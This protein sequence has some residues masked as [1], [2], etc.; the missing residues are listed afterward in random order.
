MNY[1]IDIM[2]SKNFE[3]IRS[4][5]QELADLAG[6]AEYYTFTDPASS[7][8]KLRSFIE[9]VVFDIYDF[10][11]LAKPF[12]ASLNDLLHESAFINVT[13][14]VVLLKIDAIRKYGNQAAHGETKKITPGVASWLVKESFD[15]AKYYFLALANGAQ[16]DIPVYKALIPS[17]NKETKLSREQKQLKEELKKKEELLNSTLKELERAR[18]KAVELNKTDA[19]LKEIKESSHRVSNELGF[20]EAET[21]KYI[22]DQELMAAGWDVNDP[23]QVGIEVPVLHQPT[24]TGDGYVDYVLWNDDGT[25]LAVVEAKRTSVNAKKGKTQA[26]HYA[27]GLEKMTGH[28]PIIFFTNG[29]D[30]YFWDDAK[31]EGERPVFGYYS[32]DSLQRVYQRTKLQKNLNELLPN[33]NIAGRMY[34][35]EAIKRVFERYQDNFRSALI[36]QATGSGKTR[37]SIALCEMLIRAGRAKRILFLCD[38]KELRKQ[39]HDNFSEHLPGEPRILLKKSSYE[40][41]DKRIYFSTYPGMMNCYTNFDVGFFDLI[42]SDE[43]HR[44]IYNTYRELFVYFDAL[45]LGLTATPVNF[46]QRNTYKLF[47]CEESDPTFSYSYEEAVNNKPPYL[48]PYKVMKHTTKF[49]REGIKYSQLSQEAKDQLDE[50]EVDSEE[51]D[52][53]KEQV[54]KKVFNRDTDAKILRNLM[55]NGIRNADGTSLG[56]TIIFA[57]NTAHADFLNEIF[58]EEY[59]QYGGLFC[60]VI[61]NKNPRS[62][63][64]INA[65][66]DPQSEMKIAISIDMMDTGIDV[67]EVVNLVFAKPVKS[68]AKFWQMIGRGTRLCPE[69][70]GPGQDKTHFQIFDHW[71]NFE[72]FE[73]EY[74]EKEP[75][76]SKPLLQRLFEAR[77]ELAQTAL[78]KQDPTCFRLMRE[79]IE[80]DLADLPEKTIPVREKWAE[81]KHL[82][83]EGVLQDFTPATQSLLLGDMAPLMQWRKISLKETAY[84]LD[85]LIAE[86]QKELL[87][88]SAS[89]EDLKQKLI[90]SVSLLKVN[91]S[92]VEERIETINKVKDT[93]FW[94]SVT[95]TQLEEVRKDLRAIM[96]LSAKARRT[97]DPNKFINVRDS[98]VEIEEHFPKLEGLE[99]A[100]YRNRVKSV[101]DDLFDNSPALKKIRNGQAVDMEELIALTQ[102]VQSRDPSLR[103]DRL[104]I[105]FPNDA[106]RLDLAIRQVIGVNREKVE[107][108]FSNFIEK[109]PS[110]NAHQVRFLDMLQQYIAEHGAIKINKLWEKPFTV[111]NNE[112][113]DGIF[114]REEQIDDLLELIQNSE[115]KAA[116]AG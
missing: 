29:Y 113:I 1:E 6:F 13:D 64:L 79:L 58:L 3:F 53:T 57:R 8:V 19:E 34:Q 84:R 46:I 99:E 97:P 102:K 92:Q 77:V 49:L 39:A 114:K 44:S 86:L 59:P 70:F 68:Y 76:Q 74:E 111:L 89:F 5:R 50:Q 60:D 78:K 30:I 2:D 75:A 11:G 47:G 36:V 33:K 71:G 108:L 100:A 95:I 115:F 24:E 7:L 87:L 26:Y 90:E 81:K 106:H 27:E 28:R 42:I 66:K 80:L 101:L 54:S 91:L 32:K 65:F 35:I 110:L 22:I 69:L 31:G 51:I 38:R 62:E 72:Y 17:D 88:K 21:R 107:E 4:S 48:V 23:D 9:L 109:Y 40:D 93:A 67:P 105:Q 103:L 98:E 14:R 116:D 73:S 20:S 83:K 112:G 61:S 94:D 45:R 25:P 55:E 12:R 16:E 63:S 52:Y 15:I 85:L 10:N 56:K 18:A 104:L 37:V 43:S 82:Q 96:H 41:L